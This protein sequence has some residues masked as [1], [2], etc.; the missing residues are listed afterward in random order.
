[1]TKSR[2]I[3]LIKLKVDPLQ[4]EILRKRNNVCLDGPMPTLVHR[5]NQTPP[6]KTARARPAPIPPI[7]KRTLRIVR[8]QRKEDHLET[9]EIETKREIEIEIKTIENE[10]K[11]EGERGTEKETVTEEEGVQGDEET[12]LQY[13]VIVARVLK[14]DKAMIGAVLVLNVTSGHVEV[15]TARRVPIKTRVLVAA[16]VVVVVEEATKVFNRRQV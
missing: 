2:P 12:V 7:G 6:T 11:I 4:N 8:A 3:F 16:V 9:T 10:I 14:E 13:P 5:L 15:V 1:M